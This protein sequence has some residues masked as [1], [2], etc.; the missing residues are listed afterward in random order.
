MV[1]KAFLAASLA[2]GGLL[3]AGIAA[4]DNIQN[5]GP[6]A[7]D[8]LNQL[9]AWGYNVMLNGVTKDVRYLDDHQRWACLVTGTHPTVSG[10]LESGQ[11]QTVYVDLS[12]PGS[13]NSNTPSGT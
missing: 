7:G 9:E 13:D 10:P 6:Y 1:G 8:T 3:T 2:C 4:A 5:L 12:C 11:F